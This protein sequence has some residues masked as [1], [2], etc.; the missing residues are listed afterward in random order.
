MTFLGVIDGI[1]AD[2]HVEE[3]GAGARLHGPAGYQLC[4]LDCSFCCNGKAVYFVHTRIYAP[5]L[6][7]SGSQSLSRFTPSADLL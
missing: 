4:N 3:E 1:L 2:E 6:N 5:T 7:I